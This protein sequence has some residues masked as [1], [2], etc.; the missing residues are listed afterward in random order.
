MVH[1]LKFVSEFHRAV[2][3]ALTKWQYVETGLYI[4][5]HCLMGTKHQHSSTVFFHIESA[6]SKLSLTDKLC[7]LEL[8]P[9]LY[10][11]HWRPLKKDINAANDIR[12]GLA[13]FDTAFID[14]DELKRST[15]EV[16]AYPIMLCPNSHDATATPDGNVRALFVETLHETADEFHALAQRLLEFVPA[17]IPDWQQRTES[18]PQETRQLL[19]SIGSENPPS[20]RKPPSK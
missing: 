13:H 5:S 6:R 12:N 1:K 17:H 16:T 11:R 15:G 18:L 9:D 3:H 10:Q 19:A 4:L 14:P 8:Q 2:G 20:K 7:K